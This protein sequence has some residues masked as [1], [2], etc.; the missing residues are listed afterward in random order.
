MDEQLMWDAEMAAN[1]AEM[2]DA[3]FRAM[4][5]HKAL[6]SPKEEID[7]SNTTALDEIGDWDYSYRDW[8]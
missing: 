2:L 4:E 3:E 8:A 7:W 1:Q 6:S 5:E